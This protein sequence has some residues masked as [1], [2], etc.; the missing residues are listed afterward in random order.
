MTVTTQAIETKY[1]PANDRRGTRIKATAWGGTVTV[2]YDYALDA[3]DNH[4]AA[5]DA[6]I[7]KMG[8]QG[9]YAQGG[10]AKGDGGYYFVNVEGSNA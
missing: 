4:R 3:V 10:N 6:L 7:A 1:L 8:W 9:T 2:G 5:A